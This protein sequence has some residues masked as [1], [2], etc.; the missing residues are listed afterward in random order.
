MKHN[1]WM[2]GLAIALCLNT[3]GLTGAVSAPT[4]GSPTATPTKPPP[5][6]KPGTL[7]KGL[8]E[9]LEAKLGRSL[10]DTE[11]QELGAAVKTAEDAL[12]DAQDES[13]AAI[14]EATGLSLEQVK[15][16]LKDPAL[17][18]NLEKQLAR[19]LT[20]T[21]RNAIRAALMARAAASKAAMDEFI[22]TIASLTGLTEDEVK[23][24]LKPPPPPKPPTDGGTQ[25]P[26][27][28]CPNPGGPR[29]GPP[30][31]GDAA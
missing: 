13:I 27:P 4:T 7:G 28:K 5:L 1:A 24:V 29:N 17:L 25:P 15:T 18:R 21:E 14:A 11:K 12:K 2:G 8:V 3:V 23:D 31:S 10:S 16:A 26:A 22:A 9:K 19:K 6:P 20:T 30:P